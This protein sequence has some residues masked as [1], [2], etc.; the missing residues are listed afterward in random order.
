ML[1]RST[2]ATP[3]EGSPEESPTLTF[4]QATRAG[5]ILG[6]AAYMAPE[7]A[8]GKS[9]DKRADIWAFGV[10]LYEMLTG[11]SAFRGETITD[12]LAAVVKEEPDLTRVAAKV[13]RL[14]QCCLQKDP[15]RRLQA[16]G[17]WRLPLEDIPDDK[18]HR[19]VGRLNWALLALVA[20]LITA[21]VALGFAYFRRPV[22]GARVFKLSVVPPE[23][24]KFDLDNI[25][26]V[27]PDGRRLAFV[28][29]NDGKGGLWVRDL[30]SLTARILP[31]TEGAGDPFWSPDSRFIGFSAGGKLKKID[32]TSGLVQWICDTLPNGASSWSKDDNILFAT[33][34]GGLLRVAA[35][36]GGTTPVNFPEEGY[37]N[38]FPWFL[39]DGKH[40][41]YTAVAKTPGDEE[42]STVYVGDLDSKDRRRVLS[43]NSNVVYVPPGYLLFVRERVL[44][45]QSFDVGKL[46]AT[47]DPVP[48]AERVYYDLQWGSFSASQNG[49]LVYTSGGLE[50]YR[51]LALFDRSGKIV[52]TVGRPGNLNWPRMSPDGHTVAV[53][54]VD[55]Q[56]RSRDLWLYDL[57]RGTESRFTFNGRIHASPVWSPDG[58]E[59]AFKGDTE[60]VYQKST[61]GA[62]QEEVLDQS[63]G[64]TR[65]LSDWSRDGR[66]II[67]S[68]SSKTGYAIWVL[69]LFGDRKPFPYLPRTAFNESAG[70]LSP[71]GHWMA[72]QSDETKRSEIYVQSFPTPGTKYQIS[73]NGGTAPAWSWDGTE[74]Y[75]IEAE[76]KMI[77]VQVKSA[78]ALFEAS[79]PK[80]LFDVL[81]T[82]PLPLSFNVT[83][84]GR[85]LIAVPV[86]QGANAPLNVV[87]NWTAGLKK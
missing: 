87:V 33:T 53:D 58:R 64:G 25:P 77:A 26:A 59:I 36:G 10:V 76:A 54:I 55:R 23:K 74:L 50:G 78:G 12:V 8:R 14:L 11:R 1:F 81:N 67:E 31:G 15:K 7:Q 84:D 43:A 45:A 30:D 82:N 39:P 20:V 75:F 38:G 34:S 29:T 40:F 18:N 61:S 66:Y 21:V 3:R 13:R 37:Q 47:G 24:A 49:V 73:T 72:Y 4:Q 5:M 22:E 71:N 42:K 44:M 80:P 51:R 28:A 19:H 17:D 48:I 46:Q 9:V 69:P 52:G 35:V 83:K 27:S 16:I 65:W 70:T 56:A 6:T 79:V 63:E 2:E 68:F 85:F 62:G 86:E 57:K 32:I 60:H 41:L